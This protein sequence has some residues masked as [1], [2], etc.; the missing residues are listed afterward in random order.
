MLLGRR[1]N[2]GLCKR[3]F[4]GHRT[5]LECVST[6]LYTKNLSQAGLG[7]FRFHHHIA[8]EMSCEYAHAQ[9][10]IK[11][12]THASFRFHVLTL[13]PLVMVPLAE[14][15]VVRIDRL[16]R[17]GILRSRLL[18]SLGLRAFHLKNSFETQVGSLVSCQVICLLRLI[19]S[20]L[21]LLFYEEFVV[22]V[23]QLL[24]PL[25]HV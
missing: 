1:L 13:K 6:I 10:V 11:L 23:V 2:T 15:G 17:S 18:P 9:S 12:V 16:F 24:D 19:H 25:V 3:F 21:T 20:G 4:E 7:S 5:F 22:T 8:I 14:L